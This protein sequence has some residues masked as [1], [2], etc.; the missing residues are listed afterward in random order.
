MIKQ[1]ILFLTVVCTGSVAFAQE[2]SIFFKGGV[3][4]ANISITDNG[5]YDDANALT[6]FH[7]GF[8]ADLPLSKFFSVQPG[9]LFTGK[10]TKSQKGKPA[11]ASYFKATTNPYYVELPVNLVAK[12]P[13]LSAES[14]VFFG[15]GPYI[16]AGVA[17]KN[18]A[19]GKIFGNSFSYS[20]NIKFSN[21]NPLTTDY[22]E[23]AGLN[24]I[25]RFDYGVNAT[26]GLQLNNLL[27]SVNYGY[28]LAKLS[29]TSGNTNDD[30]KHRVLSVSVGI[31]L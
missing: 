31:R 12:I 6:S 20:K 3:N 26:A 14:N 27:F 29:S 30:N 11:D 24:V 22:Q 17:G 18:K 8:M 23:G 16:A 7:A 28:G 2:S 5:K 4:L 21:D 13:L 15:A 19:E 1:A 9:L 10:G 25:R